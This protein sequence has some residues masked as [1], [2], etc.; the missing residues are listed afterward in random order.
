MSPVTPDRSVPESI[1]GVWMA[2]KDQIR[3]SNEE[4][5]QKGWGAKFPREVIETVIDADAV[6]L[7]V[8]FR[9]NHPLVPSDRSYRCLL[10]VKRAGRNERVSTFMDFSLET[11]VKLHRPTESRLHAIV[12]ALVEAQQQVDLGQLK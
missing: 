3:D 6:N 4:A 8:P 1:K 10:S 12:K 2:S 9:V 11:I 5:I 7:V